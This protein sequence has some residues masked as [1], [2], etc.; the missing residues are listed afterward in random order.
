VVRI[1]GRSV[2]LRDH[3]PADLPVLR[4]WLRPRHDWHRW[5]GPYYPPLTDEQ[6]DA[7]CARLASR[8]ESGDWP[9][10]R[11]RLVIA[12][13]A[14]DRLVGTVSW[15][16]ESRETDWRRIGIT[17][18][19]PAIWSGGWGTEAVAL[20]TTYLFDTTDIVRLDFATWSGNVRM[21]RLG[22][23]LGWT[24]EGRFR[25]ARVVNGTRYD[26]VV[27]GVLRSEWAARG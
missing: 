11:E 4:E 12:D 27:Y 3:E 21:C 18:Y 8:V 6:A 17:L 14:T 19:D 2:V 20:W 25:Q 24:E 16:W 15:Y 22:E 23:R 5:D 10:P 1:A 26:S 9:T 7:F 13:P